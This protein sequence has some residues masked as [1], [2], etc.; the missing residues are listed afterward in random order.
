M[1]SDPQAVIAT[2]TD[3]NHEK[4]KKRKTDKELQRER[5]FTNAIL[6]NTGAL[7][8]VLDLKGRITQFNRTCE[9]TTGYQSSEVL[10]RIFWEFLIPDEDLDGVSQTWQALMKGS[11]PN[12]HEN[13]W[14]CKDSTRRLIA[15]SN[16]ALLSAAGEVEYV[17][18]TGL[19]ITAQRK[20]E[21]EL[22]LLTHELEARVRQKTADVAFEQQRLYNVLDTL[23]AYVILLDK[24]YHVP[25][26]N[27]FFRERFGESHGS[28]CFEYLFN[29]IAPCEN[30]ESY[31]PMT[32]G[33]PYRWEWLGPDGRNYDIYDFPF[34][35]ID[36]STLIMEMGLD[37]TEQKS[38]QDA[39]LKSRDELEQRVDERTE[40]L[41]NAHDY[42]NNLFQYANAPI[43]VW[44]TNLR[45][46]RFNCAFERLTGRAAD[47]VLGRS[48]DILFPDDSKGQTMGYISNACS[49][50]RM[51]AV[52][53]PILNIDGKVSVVLWNSAIIHA[54]DGKTPLATIAQGQDITARKAA[55]EEL[56]QRTQ[57]LE[58][59][60][61]E[62]EAF[63]YTV[64]HDL[65]APV[66]AI[67]GFSQILIEDYKD[68]LDSEG[69]RMMG[70]IVNEARRMG[71][72]IEDL[73]RFSRLSRQPMKSSEIDM[74]S[75][76]NSVTSEIVSE[77]TNHEIDIRIG[78]L[79]P[80]LG[81]DALIRQVVV[82]LI[83]NAIK[84][85]NPKD[86]AL[87]EIGGSAILAEN[88]YY[89]K[90]NGVGFD[91][92]FSD[93]LF[94]IFQRLHEQAQFDGTGVGLAIVQ[95]I[96]QR[97]GGRVWAES[98]LGEGAT[99]YFTLPRLE[100][101]G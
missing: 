20:A 77:M 27:R 69:Q 57:E 50:Q 83:S 80:A 61:K 45:I 19:D 90:D 31:K 35:E 95:R 49:G 66:R 10:G 42:L 91:Q 93:K 22:F 81:D 21:E 29:K 97:H 14:V 12:S 48:L 53:I 71:K 74:V 41:R 79:P 60:N 85:T 15:W 55:E 73:L 89:V 28:R 16:T 52:E 34:H 96:I 39:L 36:G 47:D 63:S 46:T 88:V 6:E 59:A 8:I 33:M 100:T 87:I 84:F 70:I 18:S 25:F 26:T 32:S 98:K 5:D 43:I 58:A 54:A 11:F 101:A 9:T 17:I 82:N 7:I 75:I 78:Q 38:A 1:T 64:S 44:D 72:L 62:L 23:P 94:G 65:K 99:F 76:T 2:K 68:R 24:D 30:C 56:R 67:N 4:E 13:Q 86:K 37:I 3:L 40:E 51:E 92:R